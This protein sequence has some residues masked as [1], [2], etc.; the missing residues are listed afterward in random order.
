MRGPSRERTRDREAIIVTESRI[1]R[2]KSRMI[3]RMAEVVKEKLIDGISAIRD[4]SNR[5]ACASSRGFSAKRVPTVL[6]ISCSGSGSAAVQRAQPSTAAGR[7]YASS[8]IALL[9][10][11]PRRGVI[12]RRAATCTRRNRRATHN[13]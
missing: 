11:V 8:D 10:R 1:S 3:A 13:P 12:T 9:H 2:N 6:S 4:E 5:E 7:N